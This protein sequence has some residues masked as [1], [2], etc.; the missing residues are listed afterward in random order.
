MSHSHDASEIAP[1]LCQLVFISVS[2]M[3]IFVK[4]LTGKTR[5]IVVESSTTID[6]VKLKIQHIEGIP[7]DQQHLI[8]AGKRLDNGRTLDDYGIRKEAS[9]H[10]VLQLRGMI[11]NFS[12]FDD[13]DELTEYLLKGEVD[14]EDV[15]VELLKEKADKR[16]KKRSGLE[17]K[18]TADS[19]MNV[20]QRQKLIGVANYVH[21][22][23]QIAGKSSVV[24]QDLKVVLPHGAVDRITGS[25]V[26][27]TLKAYHPCGNKRYSYNAEVVQFVL[28]RTSPTDGCIPWHVDGAYSQAVVQ[29]T[30][31]DDTLYT[32][33]LHP[34]IL[35]FDDGIFEVQGFILYHG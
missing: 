27:S 6:E 12:E 20:E 21:S 29:Y 8:F 1:G 35:S 30:L 18:H 25:D 15:S 4:T 11:S 9:L 19:I 23:Q 2:R 32:G 22:T 5:T 28:R 7:P 13:S 26:E 10:L 16:G 31:N 33:K 34:R 14:G 17:I 24:L 3:Q